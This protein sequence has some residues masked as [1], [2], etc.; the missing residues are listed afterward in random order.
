MV[1]HVWKNLEKGTGAVITQSF[2]A[3]CWI[4]KVAPFSSACQPGHARRDDSHG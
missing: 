2:G 1:R 4:Q 3:P